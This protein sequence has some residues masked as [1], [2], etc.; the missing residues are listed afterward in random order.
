MVACGGPNIYVDTGSGQVE[1]YWWGDSAKWGIDR[2]AVVAIDEAF[3]ELF[4]C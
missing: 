1:L 2:N 4:N 3:E